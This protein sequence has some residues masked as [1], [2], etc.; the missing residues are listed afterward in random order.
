MDIKLLQALESDTIT[1]KSI[2]I[3]FCF[4]NKDS[5]PKGKKVGDCIVIKPITVRAWFCIRPLLLKIERDDLPKLISN[6]GKLSP[7]FPE[8]MNKYGDLLIDIVCIG[9][10]NK[11]TEPPIWFR[12]VL[13]DNSTW[14]DIGILLN[15]ILFR[16]GFFPFCKSITTL[17]SVSP[18]DEAEMIAAQKNLESWQTFHK[19]DF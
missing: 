8:I 5:L 6:K 9:I 2:K 11:A 1:E 16:I 4:K 15:A 3:P 10:H 13:M 7:E 19:Q 18:M 14:Q 17:K 12:E